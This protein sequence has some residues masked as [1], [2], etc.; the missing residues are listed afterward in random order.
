M[1]SFVINGTE[2]DETDLDV[3]SQLTLVNEPV[4]F[5]LNC[6]RLCLRDP[7]RAIVLSSI[8]SAVWK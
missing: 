5:I 8:V 4:F 7:I 2:R 3:V 6:F 1:L